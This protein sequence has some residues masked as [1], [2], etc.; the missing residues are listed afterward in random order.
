MPR[1]EAQWQKVE[2]KVDRLNADVAKFKD[3]K[4]EVV[5]RNQQQDKELKKSREEVVGYKGAI[6]KAIEKVELNFPNTEDG[7][8]YLEGY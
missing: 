5:A 8:R 7:Q 6:R 1:S 2:D 4:N 3:E